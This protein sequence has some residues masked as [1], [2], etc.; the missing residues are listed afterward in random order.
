MQKLELDGQTFGR[1]TV[2][3]EDGRSNAGKVQ[4]ICACE[5]GTREVIVIGSK[6]VNAH[7]RSCGCIQREAASRTGNRFK[8]LLQ[9]PRRLCTEN[10]LKSVINLPVIEPVLVSKRFR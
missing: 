7:T 10:E 2:L 6:L 9:H 4:W 5:C 3:C 1:L 8:H